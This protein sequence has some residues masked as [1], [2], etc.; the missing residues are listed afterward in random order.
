MH[1]WLLFSVVSLV[2]FGITGVTQKLSTNYISFELSFVWF[3]LAMIAVSIVTALLVPMN[4]HLSTP[5]VLLAAL[6]GLLNGLGALT[7]FAA[8]AKGGKASIV[9]PII[10]LFPLVTVGGAWVFLGEKLTSTQILGIV[11]ALLA[12][13]FLSQETPPAPREVTAV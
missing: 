5:V 6:G 3:C 8:F 13:V 1:T 10:N 9:T 7:S 2:F 11:F 4:W 12:I